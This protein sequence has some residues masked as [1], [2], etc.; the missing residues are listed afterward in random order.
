MNEQA[1]PRRSLWRTILTPAV[2]CFS[3]AAAT[4]SACP[5]PCAAAPVEQAA[6]PLLLQSRLLRQ[7]GHYTLALDYFEEGENLCF[8]VELQLDSLAQPPGRGS[9]TILNPSR[10]SYVREW[11]AAP[12]DAPLLVRESITRWQDADS[13][14]LRFRAHIEPAAPGGKNAILQ[15]ALELDLWVNCESSSTE[16]IPRPGRSPLE[17]SSRVQ[18][19]RQLAGQYRWQERIAL[20]PP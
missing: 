4:L 14:Q 19:S 2:L 16:L 11:A 1:G 10:E 8:R 6:A 3:A 5:P 18:N 7:G 9:V 15:L 13:A 17:S 20:S 12:A